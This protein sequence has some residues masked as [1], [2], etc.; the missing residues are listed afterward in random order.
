[1]ETLIQLAGFT[2][3]HKTTKVLAR[4]WLRR[5]FLTTL[6]CF[7]ALLFRPLFLWAPAGASVDPLIVAYVHQ[8]PVILPAVLLAAAKITFGGW[9]ILLLLRLALHK[10]KRAVFRVA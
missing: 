7:F 5:M 9:L 2:P 1:M 6:L 4:E 10:I 3:T 8:M